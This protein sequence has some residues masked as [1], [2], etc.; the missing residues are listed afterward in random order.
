DTSIDSLL[1]VARLLVERVLDRLDRSGEVGDRCARHELADAQ[2]REPRSESHSRD[3]RVNYIDGLCRTC[4]I[5]EA[6][7]RRGHIRRGTPPL[8]V[9]QVAAC[10]FARFTRLTTA[11]QLAEPEVRPRIVE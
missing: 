7:Q 1:P 10:A 2:R 4:T 9:E 5:I 8:V 6:G 11:E 3:E